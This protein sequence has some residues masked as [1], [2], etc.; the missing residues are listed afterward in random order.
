MGLNSDKKKMMA[1]LFGNVDALMQEVHTS[2]L[3][4]QELP[5]SQIDDLDPEQHP[6][7]K[8]ISRN[9]DEL[10]ESIK[11]VGVLEPVILIPFEGRFR[12]L[13][14]HRRRLA[15]KLAG[16]ETIP[17][18]VRENIT[19][20][21]ADIIITD[22]NLHSRDL[23]PS[24]RG[25][26]YKKQLNALKR[27]GKRTDLIE[28]VASADEQAEQANIPGKT[29]REIIADRY[30]TTASEISKYIRV[31]DKLQDGL[32]DMVDDEKISLKAGYLLTF[33]DCEK[34]QLLAVNCPE[35]SIKEAQKIREIPD[36]AW[37]DFYDAKDVLAYIKRKP[38]KE[39]SYSAAE[40]LKVAGRK[41][42][43]NTFLLPSKELQDELEELL[44]RTAAEFVQQCT[45]A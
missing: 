5:L 15:A 1:E 29:A 40:A 23:L 27:Q 34:Q 43:R 30:Q 26:A 31:A 19:P 20:E 24:E 14:G 41:F 32:L 18:I 16:L 4:I 25:K 36:A 7:Y 13:A 10:A 9:I 12:S 35:L 2:K 37:N 39:V 8:T 38:D 3:T 21:L 28:A 44:Y 11:V 33:L 42:K 45:S 6:F 17:A 22:T